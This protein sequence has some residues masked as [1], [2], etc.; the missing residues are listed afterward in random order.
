MTL[1]VA[2]KSC[3]RDRDAGF[4]DA[5]RETWGR[6][7]K[8]RGVQVM[9]FLGHSG[10]DYF[11]AHPKGEATNLQ[12]DEAVVD[13][14]DDYNSLPH[15]TRGIC[16]W[17]QP[18]MFNHL[19]LCDNDTFINADALLALP[20][21]IFDYAGYFRDGTQE[22]GQT[23]YYK[24]H[25]GEYPDCHAWASGGLGYFIS[26]RAVE[27][28]VNTYPKIWAED[29]FIGQV[30]G[31]EIKKGRMLGGSLN[32]S[33]IATWHYDKRP[34]HPTFTSSILRRI[35]KDGNPDAF[36]QECLSKQ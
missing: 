35:Y 4:H 22:V 15:K 36:Y 11:M 31:P 26:R 25:M 6:D 24:D 33:R 27:L 34:G 3:W 19:F 16:K 20:F 28:I 17:A 7:L 29:M 30:L 18:K 12:R 14:A 21:E 8:Q 10:S 2:I 9:F 1:L 13:A 32:M 23:F 5:I